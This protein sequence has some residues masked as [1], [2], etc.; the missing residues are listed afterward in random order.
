MTG[1]RRIPQH[2]KHT[3]RSINYTPTIANQGNNSGTIGLV[4]QERLTQDHEDPPKIHDPRFRFIFLHYTTPYGP[5]L[6][7]HTVPHQY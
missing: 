7:R 6:D 3:P 2:S 1:V 5:H 4:P